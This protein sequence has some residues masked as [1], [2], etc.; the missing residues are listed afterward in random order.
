VRERQRALRLL[1]VRACI[2]SREL[3]PGGL[4]EPDIQKGSEEAE[5]Y[6]V[7]VSPSSLQSRWVGKE[8]R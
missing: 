5:A 4:L 6:A 2:G 3:L 1:G 7:V 8:L